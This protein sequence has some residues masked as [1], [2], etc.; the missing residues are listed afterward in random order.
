MSLPN[1]EDKQDG[2]EDCQNNNMTLQVGYLDHRD[3]VS[4]RAPWPPVIF[5]DES[6]QKE[7]LWLE[8]GTIGSLF[9]GVEESMSTSYGG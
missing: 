2:S 1:R 5:P 6:P 4:K 3:V 8:G 9:K 7:E